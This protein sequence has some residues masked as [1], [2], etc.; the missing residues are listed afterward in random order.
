MDNRKFRRRMLALALTAAMTAAMAGSMAVS[1]IDTDIVESYGLADSIQEGTI[2]HCFDWKYSDIKAELPNIA[3]AGFTSIQTSP[4]QGGPNSGVWYWLYQPLGFSVKTSDIGTKEE[5]AELCAAAEE[6]GINIIVDVVANHLAGN[7]RKQLDEPFGED[8]YW[9]NGK[10]SI[11]YSSRESITH[12]NLGEYGDINSE[13]QTV[14]DA[15]V[16]YVGELKEL[17]VDGIRWDAAKHIGLPSEEC[18]FWSAVTD[19]DLYHYGEILDAPV[20]GDSAVALMNEY[21]QYMNVTDN[22]YGNTLR[23]SFNSGKAPTISGSWTNDGISP[24]KLVY[25]G[26]SHDTYANEKGKESNGVE[27]NIIDRAYAVAAARAD[28]TALYLSRP[29]NSIPD[30]MM[31]GKKGSMHFTAPEVAAV[32]HFHNAASDAEDFYGVNDNVS[33]VVRQDVGA[34]IV[35]GEGADKEVTV[36][37][38]NS[39]VPAGEYF[40]EVSGNSFTVTEKQITGKVGSSG[41]AVVYDSK[42]NFRVEASPETG[43]AFDDKLDVT[44]RCF[45]TQTAEYNLSYEDGYH[46]FNDGDVITIGENVEP[47]TSITLTVKGTDEAGKMCSAEYVYTK[48]VVK[49]LPKL[50]KGGVIFN[51][52]TENWDKVFVWVYDERTTPGV[53]VTNVEKWPGAE[54]KAEDDNLFTYEFPDDFDGCKNI[55]IIFNNGSGSQLPA[56][57][58]FLNDYNVVGFYNGG[59]TL[60]VVQTFNSQDDSGNNDGSGN[61]NDD[62]GSGNDDN[63][64]GNDDNGNVNGNDDN[65]SGNVDNGNNNVD[66]G[67]NNANPGNNNANPGNNNANPGNNNAN[68]GNNNANPGNNNVTPGNNNTNTGNGT[69]NTSDSAPLAILMTLAAVSAFGIIAARKKETDEK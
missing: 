52:D 51:N 28:S 36:E 46:Q 17:G 40:D 35:L 37:N 27:Q 18:G 10:N 15:A 50:S 12:D 6:Y 66:P 57:D 60:E 63:G 69:V 41:I 21:T 39:A 24:D 34:V 25:W 22:R 56:K 61:G 32:N 49:E 58:G 45:G 65:G 68:P 4:A 26:E 11:S 13:N 2:L 64:S 42:F 48:N 31:A 5:L 44:L 20:S 16:N 47:G 1:G 7:N 43:T 38:I 14:I 33:V 67:N 29:L 8:A 62:N 59:E 3:K 30:Q 23:G 54:M 53:T 9:H 19:N 55:M